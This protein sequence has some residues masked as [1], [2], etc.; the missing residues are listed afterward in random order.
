MTKMRS[1]LNKILGTDPFTAYRHA[2]YFQKGLSV[3]NSASE[4]WTNIVV[5][6]NSGQSATGH[7]YVAQEPESFSYDADGNLIN[8]GRFTYG[9]D[10]E[11]RLTNITSLSSAP[12]GSKVKLNF[13]YDY[14]GRRIQKMVSTNNGSVY[15]PE[16]TNDFLYDGWNLVG[17][18]NP[19][20][21]L[22][23]S[24]VWGSDL[25]GSLQGAGGVGGLLET[26][27][28]GVST[29]FAAFDGNGNVAAL[30]SAADGTLTA[31][32]EYGPFGEPIRMTG[33]M[34][35]ANPF[36]FST[37]YD[38]DESDLLYY[39]YRYYKP[40]TGT[41][42]SRDPLTELGSITLRNSKSVSIVGNYMATGKG[43]SLYGFSYNSP[44]IDFDVRGLCGNGEQCGPDITTALYHTLGNITSTFWQAG[45]TKQY[46][47]GIEMY[48]LLGLLPWGNGGGGTAWDID[49]LHAAGNNPGYLWSTDCGFSRGT[50]PFCGY[51]VTFRGQ[52][53]FASAVNYVMWGRMNLLEENAT[54][55]YG[56]TDNDDFTLSNAIWWADHYKHYAQHEP[57]DGAMINEV[58]SFVTYGYTYQFSPS[59][60]LP[61]GGSSCKAT[62]GSFTWRWRYIK[63]G[64][65]NPN[66]D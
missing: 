38:D 33:L 7:V 55:L 45:E 12:T 5:S 51:G 13:A 66:P 14:Q 62:A 3:N 53:Y 59:G 28:Y 17:T 1:S 10:G 43:P 24:F 50:G 9:W 11:N 48:N 63:W 40:S 31:N 18:L 25:S 64:P 35:R 27:D 56:W 2:E 4:L 32:Y 16:Y 36:R 49:P 19:A 44:L 52:C 8:D 60:A 30:V 58:N 15:V 23:Q 47:A 61:C 21:S 54:V 65:P 29:N 26:I 42:I 34:A 46:D 6:A 37:K 20:S 22:L 41:W 57:W 39:G